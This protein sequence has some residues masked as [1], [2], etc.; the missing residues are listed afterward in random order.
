VT[1]TG[2]TVNY[3]DLEPVYYTAVFFDST[4]Q[5]IS[6]KQGLF[7]LTV[8]LEILRDTLKIMYIGSYD[9]NFINLPANENIIDLG[10][11]PIF[12]YFVG[13]S[14]MHFNC[15][16]SDF[17]CKRKAKKYWE[18]DQKRRDDYFNKMNT[19]IEYFNYRF[20]NKTFKINIDNN[21]IDLK[22]IYEE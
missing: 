18:K 22:S 12:E 14:M 15:S 1:I 6:D 5:T 13:Y 11:I 2:Q 10:K 4:F 17:K 8:P 3:Q 21:C 19:V 20:Q 16:D 7:E 9:L